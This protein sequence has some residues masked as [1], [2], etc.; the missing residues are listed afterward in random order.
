MKRKTQKVLKIFILS[1][2]TI[3]ITLLLHTKTKAN[4]TL[5]SSFYKIDNEKNVISRIEPETTIDT[6]KSKIGN[7]ESYASAE[8][9]EEFLDNL[10]IY[11]EKECENEVTEGFVG[12]GMFLKYE[13]ELYEISVVGDFNGDGKATQVELTNTI[14][15]IVGLNGAT[16]EGIKYESA[17][18]T[19]D[20]IV[21]QRDI[22]KFIRY[23]VYGELDLGKTDTT[24]PTVELYTLKQISDA[25]TIKAEAQDTESGMGEN[26]I[27]TFYYKKKDEPENRYI[28]VYEGTNN[29]IDLSNLEQNTWYD[30][31]VT[32]KDKAGN[33]GTGK[34]EALTPKIPDGIEEGAI[35]FGETEWKNGM[36]SVEINTTIIREDAGDDATKTNE[37][38]RVE[39]QVNGTNG[40]WL[41]GS[42]QSKA[43]VTGLKHGDIVYARLTDG[44]NAG[45]FIYKTIKDDIEPYIDMNVIVDD[46]NLEATATVIEAK[47]EES[48]L[49]DT[50]IYTFYIKETGADDSTYLQKQKGNIDNC[51]FKNLKSNTKYTIKVEIQDR[52]GNIG[53]VEKEIETK[54]EK[55]PDGTEEGAIIFE[56]LKWKDGQAEITISTKTKYQIEYQINETTGTWKKGPEGKD[57]GTS[58]R[59]TGINN[60][61]TVYAR[62]TDGTTAGTYTTITI[63]DNII[64][65]LEVITKVKSTTEIQA[66]AIATDDETGIDS[67][68]TYVFYIKKESEDDSKY[69][70]V[71]N[72]TDKKCDFTGLIAGEKYLIKVEVEDRAG[73]KA[74]KIVTETMEDLPDAT[75]AGSIMFSGLTWTAGTAEVTISTSTEYIIEYQVNST[76]GAWTK[77]T[78]PKLDVNVTGL[79]HGDIIYARLTDGTSSGSYAT[80]TVVDTIKPNIE[81]NLEAREQTI[82]ATAV[83]EDLESGLATDVK[84]KFYI[85]ETGADDSTY[86][87][88]QNTTSN[89]LTVPDLIVGKNYTIKVEV[90]DKAENKGMIEKSILIP[91]DIA[92][93]VDFSVINKTSNSAKVKATATDVGGLPSPIIYIF[94]IKETGADD[95]TYRE[96]QNSS[97]DT[98]E[99]TDLEQKKDYTV[100][101]TVA[102]E[103]GNVGM[104]ERSI[105]TDGIPDAT[106][107][108]AINFESLTWK[109]TSGIGKAEVVIST[110]TKYFI[111]YQINSTT[112]KW[113]KVTTEGGKVTVTGLNN[114]DIIY[115]RLT[116]GKSSSSYAT[117]TVVDAKAPK[118][119]MTTMATTSEIEATVTA[120]DDETGMGT[121]PTYKFSI[122]TGTTSYAEMYNGTN[123]T[124][125]FIDLKAGETYTVKV[126]T[127][128]IA[129]N[130]ATKEQTITTKS[131]PVASGTIKF[132]AVVWSKG[133][134]N[135]SISTTEKSLYIEYQINSDSGTWI[136]ATTLGETIKVDNLNHGDVIYARLTDGKNA[137]KY[138]TLTV[139]DNIE[140]ENF[141]ISVT[142]VK[143]DGFKVSGSTIDNQSGLKD[144][145][146]VI[147]KAGITTSKAKIE[148]DNL[149]GK[150]ENASS[151]TNEKQQSN[152][153]N[154]VSYN[155][156]NTSTTSRSD[157]KIFNRR[158]WTY[159][160]SKTSKSRTIKSRSKRKYRNSNNGNTNRRNIKRK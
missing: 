138:A 113:T 45:S 99:L 151:N 47:D 129:G 15:Y 160:K 131:I 38:Y 159:R 49:E 92:P 154:R 94:Y 70:L 46:T 89:I 80:L 76:T 157:N 7:G 48:G 134:A 28:K 5:T 123:A 23:I 127:Q 116:D 91:D 153:I 10:Q 43:T 18:I 21:D 121:K 150:I 51:T 64:P 25:M 63:I 12:T 95:S 83:A 58:I 3:F 120:V 144:Y 147:E 90:E 11:K 37:T 155:N 50:K 130:I 102:D 55:V 56:D 42:E 81:L 30:I 98:C 79:K 75:S 9:K 82:T 125:K 67:T 149:G 141:T 26:P 57:S 54:G 117:L 136:K 59:L 93:V 29:I 71:Q 77:G 27:Y 97:S 60:N 132:G 65:N 52:A 118:L 44:T 41:K 16:L 24:P 8:E 35:I 103:T 96:V 107:A 40:K 146:Y 87:E 100:K 145:T 6:L 142:N 104:K 148:N 124:Y 110:K 17:D 137:G 135:V 122:K 13:E 61:D 115:A 133:K 143:I 53:K 73:N 20:G 34:G 140:P 62:L 105:L 84:Y 152:N 72:T 4:S 19:G 112:G 69:K 22:T 66:E 111:E 31:K 106:E 32:V 128:D 14:R 126:E 158:K 39:Y 119:E 108:G 86:V 78:A 156:N 109:Q 114:N 88:K 36:A 101:V 85:K 2:I 68:A 74:T 1:I 139:I 33:L